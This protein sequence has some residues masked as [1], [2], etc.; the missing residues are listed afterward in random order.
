LFSSTLSTSPG[1]GSSPGGPGERVV[2]AW[3][4]N[5]RP[6]FWIGE[7]NS[8]FFLMADAG[9]RQR[10]AVDARPRLVAAIVAD[11]LRGGD[12]LA[13]VG[14]LHGGQPPRAASVARRFRRDGG[15]GRVGG[16]GHG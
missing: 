3:P 4:G 12:R 14:E 8:G 5:S 2:R 6:D 16:R 15:G 13:Q 11:R 1:E 9:D 7:L 10:Q